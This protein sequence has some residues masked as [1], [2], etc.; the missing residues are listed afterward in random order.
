ML[1]LKTQQQEEHEDG[2]A[3]LKATKTH[4][5]PASTSVRRIFI[6]ASS[7]TLLSDLVLFPGSSNCLHYM[8]LTYHIVRSN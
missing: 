1:A 4:R 3:A 8:A 5:Y 7:L 2:A 6:A